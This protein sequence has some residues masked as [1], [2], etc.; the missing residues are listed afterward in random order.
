MT[1]WRHHL[2]RARFA[3]TALIAGLLIAAAVVM[4]VVQILLP[5]A[6]RYP[7]FVARQLS[8]R[9]H[10]PVSFAA[11]SSQWQPSGPLLTVRDLTLG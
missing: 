9:L 4:G 6:T 8:S 10:R 3:L 7:D 1:P 2:R 11:I 5:V